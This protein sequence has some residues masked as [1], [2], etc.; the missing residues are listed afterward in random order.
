MGR[1]RASGFL[2]SKPR[3]QD[4]MGETLIK[5]K[6]KSCSG[7]GLGPLPGTR[8][9]TCGGSGKVWDFVKSK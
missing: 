1:G 8:C 5:V 9:G 6:C 3:N 2:L 4:K 7:T